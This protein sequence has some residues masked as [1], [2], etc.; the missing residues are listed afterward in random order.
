[1]EKKNF[2]EVVFRIALLVIGGGLF[3]ATLSGLVNPFIGLVSTVGVCLY[4][5]GTMDRRVLTDEPQ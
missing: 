3:F 2:I 5:L 4:S 1:M